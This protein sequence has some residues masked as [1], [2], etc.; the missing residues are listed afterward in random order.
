MWLLMFLASPCTSCKYAT[1]GV[2]ELRWIIT[3]DYTAFDCV[4]NLFQVSASRALTYIK[5]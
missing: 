5:S 1:F 3:D 4:L 2:K